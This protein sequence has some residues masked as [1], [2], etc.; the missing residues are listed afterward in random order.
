MEIKKF[1]KLKIVNLVVLLSISFY[2]YSRFHKIDVL[3]YYIGI[4]NFLL[5]YQSYVRYQENQKV[6]SYLY[7][8]ISFLYEALVEM[9]HTSDRCVFFFYDC[10]KYR[11]LSR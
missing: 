4:L 8:L 6:K 11:R 3:Y 2:L 5:I 10:A 7:A 1:F 9:T